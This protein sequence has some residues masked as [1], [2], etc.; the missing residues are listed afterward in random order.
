MTLTVPTVATGVDSG[1]QDGENIAVTDSTPLV[2]DVGPLPLTTVEGGLY[3]SRQMLQRGTPGLDI[4]VAS[5]LLGGWGERVEYLVLNG[6]GANGEPAGI[7]EPSGISTVT[8]T[9]ASPTAAEFVAKVAAAATTSESDRQ[10]ARDTIV[11]HPRRWFTSCPLRRGP[12]RWSTRCSVPVH[13]RRPSVS[14]A[15]SPSSR[16]RRSRPPSAPAPTRTSRS[17]CVQLTRLPW[18]QRPRSRCPAPTR[19]CSSHRRHVDLGDDHRQICRRHRGH[20]RHRHDRHGGLIDGDRLYCRP[21]GSADR[22]LLAC[23][24]IPWWGSRYGLAL[25]ELA[26]SGRGTDA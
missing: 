12:T 22:W 17:S 5:E 11:V 16:P 24:L 1:S 4:F 20:R 21:A 25:V 6:S 2:T 18:R 14:S 15:G 13:R 23:A 9:D 26:A 3:V 19:R 7:L 8:Y 10:L